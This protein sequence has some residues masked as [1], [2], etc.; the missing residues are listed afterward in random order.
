[1]PECVP[2]PASWAHWPATRLFGYTG[3]PPVGPTLASH[4]I[5]RKRIA[6]GF[7]W[8]IQHSSCLYDTPYRCR[9]SS[10]KVYNIGRYWA[11]CFFHRRFLGIRLRVRSCSK[12]RTM[13]LAFVGLRSPVCQRVIVHGATSN[14]AAIAHRGHVF[15][16][17]A[18]SNSCTSFIDFKHITNTT[19]GQCSRFTILQIFYRPTQPTVLQYIL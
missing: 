12:A 7:C 9:V 16:R 4:S 6:Q 15:S 19:N 5:D 17:N 2:T 8:Q 3:A 14:S 11:G 1:M 10:D 18:K 13:G